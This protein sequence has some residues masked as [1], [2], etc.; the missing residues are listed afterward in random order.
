MYGD[1]RGNRKGRG[2]GKVGERKG[3]LGRGGWKTLGN[4]DLWETEKGKCLVMEVKI[5]LR[6]WL[7]KISTDFY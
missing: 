6:M 4:G 1:L 2:V 3:N 7:C 5:G